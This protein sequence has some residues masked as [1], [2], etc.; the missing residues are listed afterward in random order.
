[1]SSAGISTQH[2]GNFALDSGAERASDTTLTTVKVYTRHNRNCPKRDRSDW[3]RCNYM[4]WLY[5]Y[6]DGKYKLVSARLAVG[7]KRGKR[8][9]NSATPLIPS[10][11]CNV[12]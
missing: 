7:K 9:A 1:M 10:S 2:L 5:I 4:K 3:A 12:S 8:Q 11:S 6:C